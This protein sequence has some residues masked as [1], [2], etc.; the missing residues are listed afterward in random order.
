MGAK[1]YVGGN[2]DAYTATLGAGA[3]YGTALPAPT[4]LTLGA[5]VVSGVASCPLLRPQ[6]RCSPIIYGRENY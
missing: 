3:C 4:T 6:T 5:G 2:I 1:G